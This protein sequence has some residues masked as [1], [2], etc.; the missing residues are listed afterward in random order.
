MGHTIRFSAGALNSKLAASR[1]Y[2]K[3]SPGA[4]A[5]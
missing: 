5:T 2:T 1:T 3:I 4:K